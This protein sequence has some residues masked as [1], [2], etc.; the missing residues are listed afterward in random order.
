MG[1]PS[2]SGQ[3]K[4]TQRKAKGMGKPSTNSKR[5]GK[6]QSAS[7]WNSKTRK[8]NHIRG[9]KDVCTD[10]KSVRKNSKEIRKEIRE[11]VKSPALK[12]SRSQGA[13]PTKNQK[14]F[15]RRSSRRARPVRIRR[16]RHQS[17][18]IRPCRM[19]YEESRRESPL[20]Q[21]HG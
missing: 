5:K 9:V 12:S 13:V 4:L 21:I 6:P 17:E 1:K 7:K 16:A 8:V 11:S 10:V 15:G 2:T 18:V 3:R 20:T 14:E 19:A